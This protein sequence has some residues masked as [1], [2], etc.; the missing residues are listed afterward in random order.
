M[1]VAFSGITGWVLFGGLTL[2]TGSIAARWLILPR[3]SSREPELDARLTREAARL[4][5]IGAVAIL[6]GLLLFF[7]RQ[8]VE[9]RDPFSPW[10]AEAALL[11]GT[12]WGRT[13]LRAIIGAAL[14]TF[15]FVMARRVPA[16][17]V[18]ATPLALA[19]GAFPA[20]TGHAAAADQYT[21]V[22]LLADTMH[23]WAAG[24][25]VGGLAAVLWLE[26]SEGRE[27]PRLSL[28]ATLVPAFSSVAMV[29][30]AVLV[31]TGALAS[32]GHLASLTTL[33]STTWG[34]LLL[35][36]LGVVLV[37]LGFGARNFR[38]LTPRLGTDSGDR[39]MRRSAIAE[40]AVMQ[41]ILI[42][43]ALLVRTSPM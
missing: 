40:L 13:W 9:F 42:V 39:A 8:L 2:V 30:V 16:G 43:T 5:V 6:V 10:S 21:P 38:I 4:G 28:L 37:V 15:A 12:P 18:F 31:L 35:A 26:L 17:W 1:S 11:L 19:L 33:F 7:G 29:S 3:R 32:W 24:A 20:F 27:A 23:V 22:F 41:V 25:W 36:K 14:L 34:R